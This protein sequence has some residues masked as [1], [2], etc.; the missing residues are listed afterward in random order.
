MK[1]QCTIFNILHKMN[2]VEFCK[3]AVFEVYW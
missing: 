1:Q 3:N 2:Q